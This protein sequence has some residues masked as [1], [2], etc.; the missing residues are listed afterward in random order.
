MPCALGGG[1]LRMSLRESLKALLGAGR[2]LN[3]GR[4][5]SSSSMPLLWRHGVGAASPSQLPPTKR[6]ALTRAGGLQPLGDRGMEQR[7][8]YSQVKE[9][10]EGR[11]GMRRERSIPTAP[12]L[13]PN[14]LQRGR[15]QATSSRAV[16]PSPAAT[17]FPPSLQPRPGAPSLLPEGAAAVPA[18]RWGGGSGGA[19]GALPARGERPGWLQPEHRGS[20][21]GSGAAPHPAD[22]TP[23]TCR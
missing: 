6:R 7:G 9:L 20:L 14:F 22:S 21:G 15:P 2:E 17:P 12:H 4:K 23:C 3:R 19:R 5:C 13:Q 8:R 11:S 18:R 1:S 16:A 10:G